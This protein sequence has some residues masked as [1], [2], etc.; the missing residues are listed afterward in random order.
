MNNPRGSKADLSAFAR[1]AC[2][3]KAPLNFRRQTPYTQTRKICRS[4]GEVFI[5]VFALL[6]LLFSDL[7]VLVSQLAGFDCDLISTKGKGTAMPCL[8]LWWRRGESNPCPKS[9]PRDLLR[10]H[11]VFDSPRQNAG[12]Q[13]FPSGSSFMHGRFKSNRRLTVIAR[14]RPYLSR[15][16]LKQDGLSRRTA[17][18]P[19]SG[20]KCK[21]IVVVCFLSWAV[22]EITRLGPLVTAQ[23][24]RRNLYA[25]VSRGTFL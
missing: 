8:F 13:A 16:T 12:A 22:Y 2:K 9:S 7:S 10:A 24:P 5:S 18:L 15:D 6:F 20:S 1:P 11:C 25:P 14:L 21:L 19:Y 23:R 4:C 3:E 17:S